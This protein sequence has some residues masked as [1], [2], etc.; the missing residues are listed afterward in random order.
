[1]LL[2]AFF[3]MLVSMANFNEIKS[4]Q[5]ITQVQSAFT[6]F[7]AER[8]DPIAVPVPQPG[9]APVPFDESIKK[10]FEKNF[11]NF[12]FEN[13]EEGNS[14]LI[15]VREEDIFTQD[16][17]GTLSNGTKRFFG[18]IIDIINTPTPGT[19][20]DLEV[21]F[22]KPSYRVKTVDVEEQQQLFNKIGTLAR[23]L[24]RLGLPKS[25]LAIGQEATT[26]P[27]II[28][29]YFYSRPQSRPTLSFD[30]LAFQDQRQDQRQDQEQ[31]QEAPDEF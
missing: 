1:M 20:N 23:T 21:F 14:V 4:Q 28:G 19:I 5:V 16:E 12:K 24:T 9:K 17:E 25:K 27:N 6:N 2:L 22:H 15:S 31:N 13:L 30:E 18:T 10:A 11:P 7:G 26:T 3:I 8:D 29:F